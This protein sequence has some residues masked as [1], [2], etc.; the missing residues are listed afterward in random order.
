[1]WLAIDSTAGERERASLEP[2][3]IN[4]VPRD[5]ILL[6]KVMATSLFSL[7]SLTLGLLA[8]MVAAWFLPTDQMGLSFSLGPRFVGTILPVMAPLV[9][10][11]SIT[12]IL[13]TAF[14]RSAREAQTHLGLVQLV[15]LLP[16]VALSLMP[17]KPALWMYAVPLLGQQ[18]TILQLLR[19]EVIA[20]LSALLTAA[21]TLL[22]ALAAFWGARRSYMTERLAVSS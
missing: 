22:V 14:A 13:V 16:S 8:F 3:L 18:L 5:R 1:M 11:L 2:L 4:P 7:A 20:P 15:P 12:Q 17:I 9:L 21:V 19:G 10:L 6:G